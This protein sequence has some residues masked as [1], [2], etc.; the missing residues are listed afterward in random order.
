MTLENTSCVQV[1]AGGVISEPFDTARE[2]F[3]GPVT[4]VVKMEKTYRNKRLTGGGVECVDQQASLCL[5][6]PLA[7][8]LSR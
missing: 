1:C 7:A 5:L 6:F 4:D 3:S 2:V 8:E